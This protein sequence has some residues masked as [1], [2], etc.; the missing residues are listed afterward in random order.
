MKA[1]FRADVWFFILLYLL[2]VSGCR[3]TIPPSPQNVKAKPVGG[4][5]TEPAEIGIGTVYSTTIQDIRITWD[6]VADA[7]FHTIYWATV[8]GVSKD[9]GAA[10]KNVTSPYTHKGR[11][12]ST[13]F[14][15]VVTT[16]I[17]GT[18]SPES[19][20]VS[21]TPELGR[22]QFRLGQTMMP[23][24]QPPSEGQP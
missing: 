22:L 6:H 19:A 17:D 20:E 10:I 3:K 23:E 4:I 24:F 21:T 5:S 1:G 2:M 18:E 11:S 14:Y 9:S 15:Y 13:T 12:L 16:T 7:D 8:P